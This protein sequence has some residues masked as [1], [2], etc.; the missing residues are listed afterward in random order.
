[1]GIKTKH[2]VVIA[3]DT[4]GSYGSLAR[5]RDIQRYEFLTVYPLKNIQRPS[6][7]SNTLKI[8]LPKGVSMAFPSI[9]NSPVGTV[10]TQTNNAAATHTNTSTG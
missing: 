7:S 9:L 5:F 2:G 10:Q 3:A 6:Y 1:M 8:I 4:L